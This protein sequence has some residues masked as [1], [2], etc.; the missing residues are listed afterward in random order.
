M[1]LFNKISVF[2]PDDF[3]NMPC[4]TTSVHLRFSPAWSCNATVHHRNIQY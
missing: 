4:P 1:K 2:S 3:R